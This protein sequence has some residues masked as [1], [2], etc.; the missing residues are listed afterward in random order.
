[1]SG[2]CILMTSSLGLR[3][4]GGPASAIMWSARS[5]TPRSVTWYSGSRGP[6]A[7]SGG[8]EDGSLAGG[9]QGVTALAGRSLVVV[10]GGLT[11][12]GGGEGAEEGG[13]ALLQSSFFALLIIMV[14]GWPGLCAMP[15]STLNSAAPQPAS[16]AKPVKRGQPSP[17]PLLMHDP[18][19]PS[20]HTWVHLD[21]LP[22]VREPRLH[23]IE[24]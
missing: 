21:L 4:R 18:T 14:G 16:P 7:R 23:G 3:D 13:G 12:G 20:I 2:S 5:T 9:S 24:R 10:A 22:I 11:A 1:M 17:S 8:T 15:L 19:R 6:L